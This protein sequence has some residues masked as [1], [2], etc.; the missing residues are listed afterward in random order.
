MRRIIPILAAAIGFGHAALAQVP[1]VYFTILTHNEENQQ[2]QQAMFYNANRT[3]LVNL[4]QYVNAHGMKWNM[5]SDQRFLNAVIQQDTAFFPTTGGKNLLRWMHEDMGVEMDPHAHETMYIYPD[6]VHLMDS[7]GLPESKV[8]GGTIYNDYNGMNIWTELVGGQY[9]NVFPDAFW[10]PLYMMGGGTPNHEDDL[11]YHGFWN[12]TSTTDYLTHNPNSP[13]THLGT[14]CDIK[15]QDT[16]TV[17]Y[18]VGRLREVIDNVQSGAYDPQNPFYLQILFFEHAT[19]N[20]QPFEDMIYAILDSM[21]VMVQAGDAQWRTF[22]EAYTEWENLGSPVFQWECGQQMP[23]SVPIAA[24]GPAGL[25]VYPVPTAGPIAVEWPTAAA[26]NLTL[27]DATGRQIMALS[28]TGTTA[29]MDLSALP[30]GPYVLRS[31]TTTGQPEL[32]M[33]LRE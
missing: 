18:T 2:F 33:V 27:L 32:R 13:L 14:G 25:S 11:R 8:I 30:S 3:R 29:R 9:G 5:Q 16:S 20:S 7:L 15:V 21:D 17:A 22:K 1:P 26:R 10:Q 28:A 19:L 31:T 12:P 4:A 24:T 6:V 23:T